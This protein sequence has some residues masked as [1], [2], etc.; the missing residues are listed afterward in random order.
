MK[1]SQSEK[2]ILVISQSKSSILPV[3]PVSYEKGTMAF[4]SCV[5]FFNALHFAQKAAGYEDIFLKVKQM[6]I[7]ESLYL[8]NDTIG[9]LPT[10]YGKSVVFHLLPF[11]Y[12]YR[13]DSVNEE[14]KHKKSIVMVITPLNSLIE[15]QIKTLHLRGIQ[16]CALR[17]ENFAKL[18]QVAECRIIFTHPETCISN[19]EG[20]QIL[21]SQEERVKACVVDEAHLVEEWGCEFRTDFSRICQL[22]SFFPKTPFLALTAT[23]P[24]IKRSKIAES[25]HLENPHIVIANLDRQNIFLHKELRK[26]SSTGLESYE[27]ILLPIAEE[28]KKQLTLYP[29]T[30]IFM[31]LKYCGYAY[32]LFQHI[33]GDLSYCPINVSK[34]P[35]NCLFGQYHA[36]QTGQMKHQLLK[37][38]TGETFQTTRVI[39]ATIALGI[40]VNMKNVSQIIHI[41]APRTLE[42]YFQE[43]GRAGRDG[44]PAKASLYYNSHDIS[45]NKPG[46][47]DEM[48]TFCRNESSCLRRALLEYM[49]SPVSEIYNLPKMSCCSNCKTLSK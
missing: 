2:R 42:A 35:E 6:K 37:Q 44:Q 15:D 48:R 9:V 34:E 28:L 43:V 49:G 19:K 16:S 32:R 26:A 31:P 20:R 30:I 8:N 46:M 38:L 18:Q 4:P 10:G 33:L 41:G 7:L 24:K 22:R 14:G 12:D 40:G 1:G 13:D 3:L 11:L 45:I 47:T 5:N 29:L 27:S 21:L 25:L 39:F 36:P 23:A 17:K